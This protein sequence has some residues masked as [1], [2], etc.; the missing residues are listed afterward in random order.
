MPTEKTHNNMEIVL[1]SSLCVSSIPSSDAQALTIGKETPEKI[2]PHATTVIATTNVTKKISIQNIL[3]NSLDLKAAVA[4]SEN[5]ETTSGELNLNSIN[6]LPAFAK[7]TTPKFLLTPEKNIN[8]FVAAK[9]PLF[10]VD[11]AAKTEVSVTETLNLNDY[12]SN[13]VPLFRLLLIKSPSLSSSRMSDDAF[14][15]DNEFIIRH[16]RTSPYNISK[17]I[18]IK[19]PVQPRITKSISVEDIVDDSSKTKIK[20]IRSPLYVTS[21]V[22]R[23]TEH[24]QV[25]AISVD[26]MT[27]VEAR[28]KPFPNGMPL[29]KFTVITTDVCGFP[30][31]CNSSLFQRIIT[32][33]NFPSSDPNVILLK[34]FLR[35]WHTDMEP[36]DFHDKLF[37]LIAIPKSKYIQKEEFVPFVSELV[38]CHPGLEFLKDSAIDFQHKYVVTAIARIFYDVN[39]SRNGQISINEFRES[40]IVET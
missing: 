4:N 34:Q 26:F 17:S 11:K 21:P 5:V 1:T 36:F 24:K 33:Y 27:D 2:V 40:R 25:S 23:L 35:F 32:Y 19:Q 18:N 16:A 13:T 12:V 30:F 6:I 3:K 37:R 39:T 8:N 38:C 14:D 28:F 20:L 31:F 22:A 15:T 10:V 29:D 7:A 9:K